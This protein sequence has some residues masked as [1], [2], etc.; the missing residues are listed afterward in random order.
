[1]TRTEPLRSRRCRPAGADFGLCVIGACLAFA[2]QAADVP[3][4]V[5]PPK[6]VV[7]QPSAAM[8][9]PPITGATTAAAEPAANAKTAKVGKQAKPVK[10]AAR[11]KTVKPAS[12]PR[13]QAKKR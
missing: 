2:V 8:A 13:A 12:K 7:I 4:A 3:I 10:A 9:P 1:M 6:P 11:Q 5:A